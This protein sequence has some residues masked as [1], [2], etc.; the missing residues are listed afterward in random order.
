V[1][2]SEHNRG[3]ALHGAESREGRLLADA[4]LGRPW[5]G[6]FEPWKGLVMIAAVAAAASSPRAAPPR[7]KKRRVHPD[8][9]ELPFST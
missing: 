4:L 8:Q 3:A 5:G 9:I 2:K 7:R 1:S 6:I